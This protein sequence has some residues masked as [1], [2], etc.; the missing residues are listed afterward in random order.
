[1]ARRWSALVA[2]LVMALRRGAARADAGQRPAHHVPARAGRVGR[3]PRLPSW[4]RRLDRLPARAGATAPTGWRT[5]RVEVGARCS[6]GVNIATGSIWGKPTWGTWW[7]WDAR[8]TSVSI[9]FVMYL[10]YLL[11]AAG[12]RGPRARA[13]DTPRCC[14]IVAALNISAR[15][16]LGLLVAHAPP[17][18]RRS[19]KPGTSTDA[20]RSSGWRSLVNFVGVRAAVRRTSSRDARPRARSAKREAASVM[21]DNW[22][23]V[24]AA[25]GLAA[26]RARRLLAPARPDRARPR[27]GAQS[28]PRR[29]RPVNR[30][31][32]KFVVGGVV[33]A[34]ALAYMIYA[35]VTQ[36]AVY[37]VTPAEL[38]AA[39][40]AGQG[41]PA[42]RHGRAPAR[43]GGIP[44]RSTCRSR[45][46]TAPP[47]S[48]SATRARR[49]ISSA[50]DAAP[51]SR[52]AGRLEGYF[53]AS[54]IMAKH[55]EEYKAPHDATQA[56]L[57]GAHQD[58]QGRRTMIGRRRLQA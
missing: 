19:L 54:L 16:L 1:M 48:R 31:G 37:F 49:P 40:V 38:R 33:I 56:G 52:A 2:G 28:R 23:F 18:R 26:R 55:S 50:R 8:L 10:G 20:A 41:V 5:R 47:P 45:S 6:L 51:W 15:P 24:L 11:L 3:L 14:G 17:A 32:T 36:S 30:R 4:L 29:E 27:C 42:R 58:A 39:P 21:P 7:T 25:Y 13:P 43:S 44:A 12:G 53:K 57:P 35:G 34:A 46:P 9:V 22:G